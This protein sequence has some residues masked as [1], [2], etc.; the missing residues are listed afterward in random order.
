M[1]TFLLI[2]ILVF[3]GVDLLVRFVIDPLASKSNKKHK[4]SKSFS[5]RFDPTMK[6]ASETMYD[7]G[8]QHNEDQSESTT[9]EDNPSD[10]AN[11][12]LER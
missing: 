7:G 5:P 6:L 2:L 4:V 12:R 11:K 3:V 1:F 8:S 10:E 9:K